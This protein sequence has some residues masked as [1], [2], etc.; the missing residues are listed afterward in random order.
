MKFLKKCY[1]FYIINQGTDNQTPHTN[2]KAYL[3]I[4]K[5]YLIALKT[6]FKCTNNPSPSALF[7]LYLANKI[8]V[9]TL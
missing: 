3:F 2:S 9:D 8:L 4:L 7:V 1:I 5:I 6:S